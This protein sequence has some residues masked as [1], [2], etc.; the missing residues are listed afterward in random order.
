MTSYHYA[1]ERTPPAP[2]VLVDLRNEETE[3]TVDQF[4]AQV[5]TA[6]DRTILPGV[7]SEALQLRKAGE[8]VF[9]G[10]G[11]KLSTAPLHRVFLRIHTNPLVEFVE[12]EVSSNEGEQWILLGRDV[13]NRYRL[14]FDGPAGKLTIES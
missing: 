7:L 2:F 12:V 14:I 8:A 11:G 1:P 5:D 4:P 13:L 3:L 9:E 10:L 6:A